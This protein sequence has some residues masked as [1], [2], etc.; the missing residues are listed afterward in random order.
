MQ[1]PGI[2]EFMQK[3]FIGTNDLRRELAGILKRLQK[4]GGEIVVTQHGKPQAVLL[5]LASY[6][7]FQELQEQIADL[8]PKL[9]KKVNQAVADIKTGRGTPAETVFGKLGI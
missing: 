8:D 9:I 1:T 2:S 5:D 6:L 3:K 4:E 7:E